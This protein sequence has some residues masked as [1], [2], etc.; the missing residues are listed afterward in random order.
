[1]PVH[2]ETLKKIKNNSITELAIVGRSPELNASDME[3]LAEALE[4]N[5]KLEALMLCTN[6]IRDEGAKILAQA[7]KKL[8][9]IK[10]LDVSVNNLGDEGAMALLSLNTLSWLDIA[11]NNIGTNGIVPIRDNSSLNSLII[12][13]N[14]L[15]DNSAILFL[16]NKTLTELIL[17]DNNISAGV[18]EQVEK[19]IQ[20]NKD[21][22]DKKPPKLHI[23]TAGIF[24][25]KSPPSSSG[26]K[27]S[28]CAAH[29][30]HSPK[31]IE[32]R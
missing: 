11:G 18:M 21:R 1:M 24:P 20:E 25:S 8:P 32:V 29:T 9:N 3:I 4:G 5:T 17:D 14:K 19:H 13:N 7:L 10:S 26:D 16:K 27:H 2:P 6:D 28:D 30:P 12:D 23:D 22:F 15:D 31:E